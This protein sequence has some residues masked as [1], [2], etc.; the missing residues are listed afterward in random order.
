MSRSVSP[1]SPSIPGGFAIKETTDEAGSSSRE[2]S[3]TRSE[4]NN[5]GLERTRPYQT[6]D[7]Q[8][9]FRGMPP[10]RGSDDP[11]V[12]DRI[13]SRAVN[14]LGWNWEAERAKMETGGVSASSSMLRGTSDGGLGSTLSSNGGTGTK[15]YSSHLNSSNVSSERA[16]SPSGDP[17]RGVISPRS[18]S[19][20]SA[21]PPR[22]DTSGNKNTISA[23]SDQSTSRSQQE[24]AQ[25]LSSKADFFSSD[26]L[27]SA[28]ASTSTSQQRLQNRPPQHQLSSSSSKEKSARRDQ[29][30]DACGKPMT[31]QF[32]RALGVVFHLD[33]FRCRVSA[34]DWC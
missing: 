32:V 28:Q 16:S 9:P 31:G 13:K 20:I 24:E 14:D 29:T 33:C 19:N 12:D 34:V 10:R 26:A 7:M 21:F 8:R 18:S 11:R 22:I 30:C 4:F 1:T 3:E 17:S 23:H 5:L 6:G 2:V 15:G 25:P 27:P